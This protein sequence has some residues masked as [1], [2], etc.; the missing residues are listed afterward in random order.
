M[1]KSLAIADKPFSTMNVNTNKKVSFYTQGQRWAAR[2]LF[3]LWL[4]ASGSPEGALAVN[5]PPSLEG[6]LRKGLEQVRQECYDPDRPGGQLG[7]L[8]D[9]LPGFSALWQTPELLTLLQQT[10]QDSQEQVHVREAAFYSLARVMSETPHQS[11]EILDTLNEVEAIP[12]QSGKILEIL[13]QAAEDVWDVSHALVEALGA[14][15]LAF[16]EKPEAILKIIIKTTKHEHRC[17]RQKAVEILGSIMSAVPSKLKEIL[18]ILREA[19]EDSQGPVREAV[20]NSL[21]SIPE[22]SDQPGNSPE[23][24]QEAKE[25]LQ[26]AARDDND[27]KVRLA[28]VE[29][30]GDVPDSLGSLETLQEAARDDNDPKV[31]L[32]AVEAL[33]DVPDSSGSL[34]TLRKAASDDEPTVRLAAKKLLNEQILDTYKLGKI[35]WEDFYD[36]VGEEPALPA[37]I[38]EIM[39]SSCPFWDKKQVKDTHLLVLIPSHVAGEPLTLDYL[40]KLI[41]SPKRKGHEKKY[42]DLDPLARTYIRSQNLDSSY[43]RSLGPDSSY[44]VLMTRDV[45]PDSRNK[46]YLEQ[47]ALVKEHALRPGLAYE[48]PR[49]LE[50]AVVT[51]L[52]HVSSGQTL[53]DPLTRCREEYPN[54]QDCHLAVGSSRSASIEPSIE[55]LDSSREKPDSSREKPRSRYSQEFPFSEANSVDITFFKTVVNS[56]KNNASNGTLGVIGLARL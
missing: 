37:D 53:F 13:E 50:V 27:P 39:D 9:S 42:G 28:A 45:L 2:V 32:A 4:L 40:G 49:A 15:I 26:E 35:V 20:A 10:A 51:A 52:Y 33:G 48:V 41:K 18:K 24:L 3:I 8:I 19:A 29:A 31:R 55:D 54:D 30:L 17:V 23:T 6:W 22:V 38:E 56:C 44:W 25:T 1:D 12:H 7:L 5:T 47:C 43:T 11:G 16:P 34:E 14:A 46:S 36:D 21:G